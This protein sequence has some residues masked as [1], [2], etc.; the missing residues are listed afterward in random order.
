[1]ETSSS[2]D[3]TGILCPEEELATVDDDSLNIGAPLKAEAGMPEVGN[4]WELVIE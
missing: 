2:R 4:H 3:L 1:M